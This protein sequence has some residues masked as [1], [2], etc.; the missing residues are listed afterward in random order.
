MERFGE[1]WGGGLHTGLPT[2]RSVALSRDTPPLHA[3]PPMR[4]RATVWASGVHGP[5]HG[6]AEAEA[7]Q[8]NVSWRQRQCRS[9]IEK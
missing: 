8:S 3:R 5:P 7:T 1:S 4:P 2:L 6:R 9:P